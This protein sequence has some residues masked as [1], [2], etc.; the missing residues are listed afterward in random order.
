MLSPSNV[1]LCFGL[2]RVIP[3]WSFVI[4]P[5]DIVGHIDFYPTGGIDLAGCEAKVV[6]VIAGIIFLLEDAIII[7]KTIKTIYKP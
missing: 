2:L 5:K 6:T 3:T 7:S 1:L 4:N